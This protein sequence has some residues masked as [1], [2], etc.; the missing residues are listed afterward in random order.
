MNGKLLDAGLL[1]IRLAVGA[2]FVKHGWPKVEGGPSGWE[3]LGHDAMEMFGITFAP[4]FWGAAAAFSE[5]LGGILVAIGLFFRPACLALIAT[6]S[7]AISYH[8]M[9][10]NDP[11]QKWELAAVYLAVFVG[12]L[13]TGPGRFAVKK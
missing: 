1:I 11:F 2:A 13:F 6:M 4:T 10:Y 8:V 3:K 5:F 12:L 9:K 7:V